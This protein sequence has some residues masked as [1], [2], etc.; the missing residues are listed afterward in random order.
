MF[1]RRTKHDREKRLTG[2]GREIEGEG[3][4]QL[5]SGVEEDGVGDE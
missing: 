3:A 2:V 4:L 5:G 1:G